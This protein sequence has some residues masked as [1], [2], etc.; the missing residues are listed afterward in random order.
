[1]PVGIKGLGPKVIFHKSFHVNVR[2]HF[3]TMWVVG[4]R[5]S[6]EAM[7]SPSLEIFNS[8]LDVVVGKLE[9]PGNL[10]NTTVS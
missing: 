5:L 7:G 1:M 10:G 3:C 9:K 4:H 2:K 8:R 6:R